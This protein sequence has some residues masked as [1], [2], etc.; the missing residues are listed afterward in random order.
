[1][2]LGKSL[3]QFTLKRAVAAHC[4]QQNRIVWTADADEPSKLGTTETQ[5]GTGNEQTARTEISGPHT[6]PPSVHDELHRV[7]LA[8]LHLVLLVPQP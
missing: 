8:Q 5:F 7:P 4:P 3:V 6:R 1:M 2:V